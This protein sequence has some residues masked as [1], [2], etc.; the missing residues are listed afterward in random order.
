M[1]AACR[2][3]WMAHKPELLFLLSNN[4]RNIQRILK[5]YGGQWP[6]NLQI[7]YSRP[8]A[9]NQQSR[10]DPAKWRIPE[11]NQACDHKSFKKDV[12]T[13]AT[14]KKKPKGRTYMVAQR[15]NGKKRTTLWITMR[16]ACNPR[17]ASKS[18]NEDHRSCSSPGESDIRN[19]DR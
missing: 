5:E 6:P 13:A 10:I 12:R 1:P 4:C 7:R 15:S 8:G 2:Q 11:T 9:K 14:P 3:L 19:V 16:R 18:Q 17:T